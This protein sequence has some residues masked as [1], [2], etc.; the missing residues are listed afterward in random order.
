MYTGFCWGNLSE[1]NHLGEPSLDETII[2]RWMFRKRKLGD[3]D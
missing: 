3:I 2:L 1:S